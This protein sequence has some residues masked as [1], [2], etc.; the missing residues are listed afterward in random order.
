MIL[1]DD[2]TIAKNKCCP[3]PANVSTGIKDKSIFNAVDSYTTTAI[4][5]FDTLTAKRDAFNEQ[6]ASYM[7]IVS[8][9]SGL[10]TPSRDFQTCLES[11]LPENDL[12]GLY[13]LAQ[14]HISFDKAYS[15]F[16]VNHGD[17]SKP[18]IV[19]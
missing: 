8:S 3:V 6:G 5:V 12:Q 9:L 13:P 10:R 4:N 16:D 18:D 7:V 2:Y 14:S 11:K 1:M 17:V 19:K 15:A